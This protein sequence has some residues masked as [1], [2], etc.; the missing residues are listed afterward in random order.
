[1]GS[2]TS[3]GRPGGPDVESGGLPDSAADA[4]A[5]AGVPDDPGTRIGG[6]SSLRKRAPELVCEQPGEPGARTH[7]GRRRSTLLR[8]PAYRGGG[9]YRI[10]GH[11]TARWDQ[12]GQ[13][14]GREAGRD[15]ATHNDAGW[16]L[17]LSP[18]GRPQAF[19][20]DERQLWIA[21]STVGKGEE[22]PEEGAAGGAGAG[23][24]CGIHEEAS[25]SI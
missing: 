15:S 23:G 18:R 12:S 7:R 16:T 24:F 8:R 19:P 20:A 9:I 14:S 11:W 21:R 13:T 1:C 22:G 10:I 3:P 6:V 17:S 25:M 5:A 4:G 2:A